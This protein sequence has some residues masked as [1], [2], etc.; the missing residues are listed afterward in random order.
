MPKYKAITQKQ[1]EFIRW[2]TSPASPTFD[3]AL[4]SA[5]RAGFSESYSKAHAYKQLVPLAKKQVA[6]RVESLDNDI[7]RSQFYSD[8]LRDS[9]KAIAERARMK[10]TDE[11][12][13][14]IQQKDQH[15][16]A[17]TIGKDRWSERKEVVN[18]SFGAISEGSIAT[19]ANNLVNSIAANIEQRTPI[20]AQYTV[21][22]GEDDVE[23]DKST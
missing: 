15:L 23:E 13:I 14:A 3:N 12:M 19:F 7:D 9:E 4:Q 17:K 1:A 22:A 20:K 16:V 10:T 18:E 8:L 5:I 6:K 21:K 11:K 2:Y